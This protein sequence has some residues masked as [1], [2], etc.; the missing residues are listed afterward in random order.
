VCQDWEAATVAAE[1][2]SRVVL[3]RTGPV[4]SPSGGILGR[5]RPLFRLMLGG[6]IGSGQQYLSWISL[7]DA[8]GAIRFLVEHAEAA[9]PV[10]LVGPK[11]VTNEQ[12]TAAL[13]RAVGRPAPFVVPAGALTALLGEAADEMLLGGPR[14]V[15]AVLLRH[16]YR[17]RHNTIDEALTAA[18]A[19]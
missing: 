14:A 18:I 9:G 5:L 13:G 1:A 11:P 2:T 16:G 15:P 17:F 7:D 6:R 10:N 3:L 12:F 4:L 8:V 19:A